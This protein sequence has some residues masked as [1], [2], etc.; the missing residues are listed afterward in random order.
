MRKRRRHIN[1]KSIK[2]LGIS[3]LNILI[4]TVLLT[5]CQSY[6]KPVEL[7]PSQYPEPAEPAPEILLGPG[8]ELDIRFFYNPGLNTLQTIRPDG[9]IALQLVGEVTAQGKTPQQLRQELYNKYT[10][11]VSQLDVT[12]IVRSFGSRRVYVGG[13]VNTPGVIPMPGQLTAVEAVM[14]AGGVDV[15]SG[16]YST[17]LVIRRSEE[18][19]KGYKLDLKEV[20]S[21]KGVHPF[22]LQPL[23]IVYVPE[24]SISRVNRW[25]DQHIGSILP[26]VGFTY[27]INPEGE[28]TYDMNFGY[29]FG[30]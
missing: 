14:L 22:Y 27:N 26:E 30:G 15:A 13:Q 2:Y 1:T 29:T 5:G 6:P 3:A 16:K 19:W 8:D 23:D 9:K 24:T 10:A 7:T 28:N 25:I 21:G 20:V 11:Y 12:V 17:V 18:G 4:L